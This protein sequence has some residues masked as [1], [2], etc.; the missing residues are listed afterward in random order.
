[1]NENDPIFS[2][3]VITAAL[4]DSLHAIQR[5]EYAQ[6]LLK[7]NFSESSLADANF[8]PISHK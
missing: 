5:E 4:F 8:T 3:E 7:K 2:N 6:E 1:M